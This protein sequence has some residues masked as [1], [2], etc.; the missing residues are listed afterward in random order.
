MHK[1]KIKIKNKNITVAT[2]LSWHHCDII[3]CQDT[4]KLHHAY[5]RAF[6]DEYTQQDSLIPQAN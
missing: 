1:V 3:G 4:S 5:W 6:I 2:E